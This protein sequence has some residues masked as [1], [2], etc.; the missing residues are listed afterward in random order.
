MGYLVVA[1]MIILWNSFSFN[2]CI[3]EIIIILLN[4]LVNILHICTNNL[5]LYSIG[6]NQVNNSYKDFDFILQ[7]FEITCILI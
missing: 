7:I 2:F 1:F 6:Y 3:V 5:R 4:L